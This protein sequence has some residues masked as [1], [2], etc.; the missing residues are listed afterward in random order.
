MTPAGASRPLLLTALLVCGSVHG[1]QPRFELRLAPGAGFDSN[2]NRSYWSAENPPIAGGPYLSLAVTAAGTVRASSLR[3]RAVYEG[4][5]RFHPSPGHAPSFAQALGAQLGAALGAAFLS[6]ELRAKDRRGL[7][8]YTD[9]SAGLAADLQLGDAATLRLL[10]GARRFLYWPLPRET[11][12]AVELGAS[13][14]WRLDRQQT[15]TVALNDAERLH[16]GRANPPPGGQPTGARRQ[17]RFF[18]AGASWS[19]RGPFVAGAGYQLAVNASNSHGDRALWHRVSLN[20]GLRLPEQLMLLGQATVVFA[21]YLDGLFLSDE[22][23][24]L[25]DEEGANALSLKLS[26]PL[27]PGLEVEAR[28]ALYASQFSQSP[29]RYSRWVAGVGLSARF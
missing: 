4:G 23:A 3:A 19:Y 11:Y 1:E 21:R 8:A 20:G 12:G 10:L 15:L 18:T 26:R 16:A 13:L 24:L 5:A 9:L 28:A 27:V 29:L 7:R 2:P 14:R 6:V 25:E 17:D 22:I